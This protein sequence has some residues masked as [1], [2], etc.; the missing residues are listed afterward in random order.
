MLG[1]IPCPHI[2]ALDQAKFQQQYNDE[3]EHRNRIHLECYICERTGQYL[4]ICLHNDCFK[5]FC[6][7]VPPNHVLSH[8]KKDTTHCLHMNLSNYRVWCHECHSEINFQK[9][10]SD[11]E[12]TTKGLVGLQNLGNTCYMNAALQSLVNTPP[13]VDYFLNC[14]L[15]SGPKPQVTRA[16]HRLVVD[17]WSRGDGYLAPQGLLYAIRHSHPMYRG[18]QQHDS[19]E[20]LR[21]LLDQIHEEMKAPCLEPLRQ[22]H[23]LTEREDMS[24]VE[25]ASSETEDYETCD[26]GVSEQSSQSDETGGRLSMNRSSSFIEKIQWK[27]HF[28]ALN[29][30]PVKV[31]KQ[32]SYRSIVSDVFNGTLL[33]SVQCLTCNR[34]SSRVET[35]QDLSL[36]IPNRDTIYILHQS[37]VSPGPTKCSHLYSPDQSWLSWLW[38]C[39]CYWIWGPQVSLHDCLSAFFSADELKGDNMY[40]CEKC[41]KLRNGVKYS[42]LMS[43]PEILCIHLKR[44][45]HEPALPSKISSHVSFPLTGLDL[46]PFMGKDCRNGVTKYDL[47]SVICHHGHGGSSGHYTCLA[48]NRT[49][50]EWYEYDDHCVTPISNVA[51]ARAYVLFYRKDN[52]KIS[53]ARKRA[54]KLEEISSSEAERYYLAK[55]WL[56][57]FNSFS[58]PGPVDNRLLLCQHDCLF[59]GTENV[60]VSGTVWKYLITRFGGGPECP[61]D[62]LSTCD[63]CSELSGGESDLLR[64]QLHEFHRLQTYGLHEK[65]PISIYWLSSWE[66]YVRGRTTIPPGPVST[67]GKTCE[68]SLG[69]WELLTSLYGVL[70]QSTESSDSDSRS[71]DERIDDSGIWLQNV[72]EKGTLLG[73]F[74]I[75]IPKH[76][77]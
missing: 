54:A 17:I 50:G 25:N 21:C 47:V 65:H 69:R 45:R 52:S 7:D 73:N 77:E 59:P 56:V 19:Q 1:A 67:S 49:T 12:N 13:L 11:K 75:D 39:V 58:E 42:R 23:Y 68:V 46:A 57:K 64:V 51:S 10:S 72:K 29:G 48:K 22:E 3:L 4:W 61:T 28:I 14:S 30:T 16:F 44:F 2:T 63:V 18:F 15:I 74:S 34:V 43:C 9:D 70:Q 55:D 6:S 26:S 36:P 24:D 76:P 20:F 31:K 38:D 27:Q 60:I 41:Q 71:L 62:I 8:Y 53:R 32:L 40:S 66:N 5:V 33:S 35:F 37:S